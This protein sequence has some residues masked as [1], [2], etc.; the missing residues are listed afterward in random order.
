MS[1]IISKDVFVRSL[2]GFAV[3]SCVLF[4]AGC[5]SM[6]G[7]QAK[8]DSPVVIEREPITRLAFVTMREP[9]LEVLTERKDEAQVQ[10]EDPV[11]A[12]TQEHS[13]GLPGIESAS[14]EAL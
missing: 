4:L 12:E 14:G 5:A 6:G 3:L 11:S 1:G 10:P 13:A 2:R 8:A 7:E 9:S